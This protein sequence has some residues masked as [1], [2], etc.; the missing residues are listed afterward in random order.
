MP[1]HMA[2][3]SA[4]LSRRQ[5]EVLYRHLSTPVQHGVRATGF[6]S[7]RERWATDRSDDLDTLYTADQ[8]PGTGFAWTLDIEHTDSH[9]VAPGVLVPMIG[10]ECSADEVQEL[11]RRTSSR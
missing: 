1:E 3:S 5:S 8:N 9:S 4:L 11:A 10:Q 6:D 7:T 2:E